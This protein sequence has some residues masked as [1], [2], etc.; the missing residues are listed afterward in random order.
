MLYK[1]NCPISF[2]GSRV[3]RGV[4]IEL[5][6]E[7]AKSLGDDVSLVSDQVEEEEAADDEMVAVADMT[8][9]QLKAE[10]KKLGLKTTGSNADL[11]ERITLHLQS[12]VD[13]EMQDHEITEEDLVANPSFVEEGIKV[14]DIIK[15][16]N[17]TEED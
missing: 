11:I 16:P 10:A 12:I 2:M 1:T 5:T 3:E 4:E 6:K 9:A 8:Q 15:I 14:G 17:G 7:Y 13:D